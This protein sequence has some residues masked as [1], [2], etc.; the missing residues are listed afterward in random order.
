MSPTFFKLIS[1]CLN[2]RSNCLC[3]TIEETVPHHTT[4]NE[5]QEFNINNFIKLQYLHNVQRLVEKLVFRSL[6]R[7]EL[8]RFL[9][10]GLSNIANGSS[11]IVFAMKEHSAIALPSAI[12]ETPSYH[13]SHSSSS[14]N[15]SRIS[16]PDI[17]NVR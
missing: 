15:R 2:S 17:A 10:G 13:L 5:Q 3:N 8:P 16:L 9:S 11:D 1:G 14:I 12:R 7:M 4:M 6:V